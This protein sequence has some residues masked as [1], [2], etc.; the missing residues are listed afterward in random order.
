MTQTEID[1]LADE[2]FS[3]VKQFVS[4]SVRHADADLNAYANELHMKFEARLK[5]VEEAPFEYV[6]AFATTKVYRKGQF[7][8]YGGSLWHCNV[9]ATSQKPGDG[10]DWTL[11][12]KA[13]RDAR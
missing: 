13:G 9:A 6:G 3:S 4:D 10:P 2:I 12:V 11:A 7:A 5:A 1:R 8:T